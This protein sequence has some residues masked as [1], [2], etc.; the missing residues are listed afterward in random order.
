MMFANYLLITILHSS[1]LFVSTWVYK[2]GPLIIRG[3]SPS[4]DTLVG[5]SSYGSQSCTNLY[6]GFTRVS[7]FTK[8]ISDAISCV[9]IGS[10]NTSLKPTTQIPTQKPI[11]TQQPSLHPTIRPGILLGPVALV[12]ITLTTKAYTRETNMYFR[13][14]CSGATYDIVLWSE[15]LMANTQY[16][17]SFSLPTGEYELKSDDPY[18]DGKFCILYYH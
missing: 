3:S 14:N 6:G 4:K 13:D 10:C 9:R 8:W 1:F 7:T 5:I 2:G 12:T 18:G 15:V 17:G 11:P 16:S